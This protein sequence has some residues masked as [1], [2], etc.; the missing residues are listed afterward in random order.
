MVSRGC[1]D[2]FSQ[3]GLNNFK[4]ITSHR[5]PIFQD[6]MLWCVSENSKVT[7]VYTAITSTNRKSTH[8]SLYGNRNC[9]ERRFLEML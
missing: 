8:N 3:L 4:T 7:S 5:I 1:V 9:R 6:L 2:R